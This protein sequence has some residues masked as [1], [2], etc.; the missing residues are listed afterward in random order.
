MD[1]PVQINLKVEASQKERWEKHLEQTHEFSTISS[2]IRTSVET[3]IESSSKETEDASPAL[4]NDIQDLKDDI[5]AIRDDVSWLRNQERNEE[6]I[7]ELAQEIFDSLEVLPEPPSDLEIPDSTNPER[8]RYQQAAIQVITPSNQEEAKKQGANPQTTAALANR[9]D[10]DPNRIETAI[11]YL[12]DQF[13]PV[14]EV[15]IEGERHYFKEE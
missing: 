9:L 8:Y 3:H 6:D 5:E 15:Q 4:S 11:E 7:S 14:V 13:L 12:Q 2:L 10:E 1:D